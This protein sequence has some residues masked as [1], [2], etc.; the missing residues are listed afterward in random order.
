MALS[1]D[2]V[3]ALADLFQDAA[4]AIRDYLRDNFDTSDSPD[5]V[6]LNDFA[7][8]LVLKS[9]EMTTSAVGLAIDEMAD[10]SAELRQITAEAKDSLGQLQDIRS[11]INLAAA[12]VGLAT[13]IASKNPG[14][15]FNAAKDL[16]DVLQAAN[17]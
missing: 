10:D 4:A 8:T 2:D 7:M 9:S 15:A 5:Y 16:R 12:V 1:S 13:A 6:A 14:G 11:F 17:A 3:G